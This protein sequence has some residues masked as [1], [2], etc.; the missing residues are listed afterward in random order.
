MAG[1]NTMFGPRPCPHCGVAHLSSLD[2]REMDRKAREHTRQM[3]I[4]RGERRKLFTAIVHPAS[5]L[6]E[7][8]LFDLS[9]KANEE[10]EGSASTHCAVSKVALR[11]L[12]AAYTALAQG[13]RGDG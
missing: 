3:T 13:G 5:G 1:E 7:D 9:E 10:I 6:S 11:R 8:D 4:R 2:C 12:I